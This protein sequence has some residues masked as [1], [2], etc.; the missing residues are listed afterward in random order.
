[1]DTMIRLRERNQKLFA[2]S[3]TSRCEC[4]GRVCLLGCR[5]RRREALHAR[6]FP[7]RLRLLA[8]RAP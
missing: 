6:D 2:S 4:L 5:E 3:C 1:M 8:H 7:H